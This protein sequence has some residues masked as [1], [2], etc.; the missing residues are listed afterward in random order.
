MF[1]NKRKNYTGNGLSP[2]SRHRDLLT[3]GEELPDL[4]SEV[5]ETLYLGWQRSTGKIG[6]SDRLQSACLRYGQRLGE[7][8]I[9]PSRAIT[10]VENEIES[11]RE[12]SIR[13]SHKQL[14]F[15]GARTWSLLH[16]D[17]P[18]LVNK[19]NLVGG[20]LKKVRDERNSLRAE[21]PFYWH[22]FLFFIFPAVALLAAEVALGEEVTRR[23]L[24]LSGTLWWLFPAAML[25]LPLVFKLCLDWKRHDNFLRGYLSAL[26]FLIVLVV[27]PLAFLRS[28]QAMRLVFKAR[29]SVGA[30]ASSPFTSSATFPRS[31]EGVGA[32]LRSE[33]ERDSE[34]PFD[35]LPQDSG[36]N[37]LA[38][39]GDPS[40]SQG[41]PFAMAAPPAQPVSDVVPAPSPAP[42][43][44]ASQSR[45][46][47]SSDR[48]YLSYAFVVFG[49][50]FPM[51]SGLAFYKALDM[52]DA[53]RK[54]KRLSAEIEGAQAEL[55]NAHKALVNIQVELANNQAEM[56][57]LVEGL[58]DS[59]DFADKAISDLLAALRSLGGDVAL[60]ISGQI[61]QLRERGLGLKETSRR[62]AQEVGA[63][64]VQGDIVL[65]AQV[66]YYTDLVG[67]IAQIDGGKSL[68]KIA[69]S[70]KEAVR[71]S[72][73]DGY[74]I[75]RAAAFA[76]LGSYEEEEK[77]EMVR[78]RKFHKVFFSN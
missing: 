65:A 34:D 54:G 3:V 35:L 45:Q 46:S 71:S 66:K 29:G 19:L 43:D 13:D 23:A 39:G 42:V 37:S 51:L 8:N 28:E 57:A 67:G 64:D 32:A 7:L 14:S 20:D 76:L 53:G 50:L 25:A 47:D 4:A 24:R 41:D 10:R 40:T 48:G 49:L 16:Y 59:N 18:S 33:S 63:V 5:T 52:A 21:R 9:P 55:D 72:I 68:D 78:N 74:D 75:G 58:G 26:I 1:G 38:S 11:L 30:D 77:L 17:V 69:R 70:R 61:E 73:Q 22:R 6:T 44:L 62:L 60:K 2:S 56:V 27:F 31:D 12:T 36:Y 15:L